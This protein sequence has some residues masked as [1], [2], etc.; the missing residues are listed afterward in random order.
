MPTIIYMS[1]EK[2]AFAVEEESHEAKISFGRGL[3][4]VCHSSLFSTELAGGHLVSDPRQQLMLKQGRPRTAE[5]RGMERSLWVRMGRRRNQ[6]RHGLPESAFLPT[7]CQA[8]EWLGLCMAN[9]CL[10][11]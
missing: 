3:W 4:L 2:L 11:R 9:S 7:H 10:C 1:V 8:L 5:C 6:R